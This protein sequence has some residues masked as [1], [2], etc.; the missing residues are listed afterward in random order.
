MHPLIKVS[1]GIT[2]LPHRP[3]TAPTP[4]PHRP[5]QESRPEKHVGAHGTPDWIPTRGLR[6][7]SQVASLAVV[8]FPASERRALLAPV[9]APTV[10]RVSNLRGRHGGRRGAPPR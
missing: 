9:L 5:Q 1:I 7:W 8:K 3:H 10:P 2:P 6:R 4:L